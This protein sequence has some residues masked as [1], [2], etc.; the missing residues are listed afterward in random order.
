MHRLD[1]GQRG[2]IAPRKG[3]GRGVASVARR[4]PRH[5][6]RH[7]A[8][9]PVAG[10]GCKDRPTGRELRQGRQ[11]R[12][13]ARDRARRWIRTLHPSA[14]V[15]RPS[16]STA[17]SSSARPFR[18]RCSAAAQGN[19]H[20]PCDGLRRAHRQAAVDL[21]HH[22]T[23]RR[24][25]RRHLDRRGAQLHRQHR[26][27][28]AHQRGPRTRPGVSA[29]GSAHQRFLWRPPAGQQSLFQQPGVHRCAHGQRRWHFQL[30]HHDIWDYDTPAAR[31]CST[32]RCAARR[33]R[34]WR[35]CPSRASPMCSIASPAC[36]CGP[37]SNDRCRR[38]TCRAK[39]LPPRSPSRP[40]PNR[41]SGRA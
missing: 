22:C 35:R 20:R 15:R 37:S 24:S 26:R 25:R 10:A 29:G 5:A 39:Q 12:S 30:V 11:G 41:S 1:E 19:A 33:F 14:P 7:L 32:S 27:V 16:W 28:G 8:W 36:R 2:D 38:A 9:L 31:C 18:S 17:W 13:E 6:V 21:P 3:P 40:C 23:A 34:P 4:R